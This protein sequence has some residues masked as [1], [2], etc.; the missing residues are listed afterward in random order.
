M[1]ASNLN[2]VLDENKV[3]YICDSEISTEHF[4]KS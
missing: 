4:L 1:K 3:V 2:D